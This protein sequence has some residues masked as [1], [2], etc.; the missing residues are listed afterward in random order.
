[1]TIVF[2]C[3]SY[4]LSLNFSMSLC[5]TPRIPSAAAAGKGFSTLPIQS[6]SFSLSGYTGFSKKTIRML[7][8]SNVGLLRC[9][10]MKIA[11]LESITQIYRVSR[12]ECARLREGV[13]YVKVYRYNP[14]HLYLKLNGYGDNGERSLKVWQ[15]LH[16]Y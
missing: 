3:V 13:P 6:T 1:M 14:K 8:V 15:L 12:E 10:T 4:C 11:T 5:H 7:N 16:T 2:N 9:T